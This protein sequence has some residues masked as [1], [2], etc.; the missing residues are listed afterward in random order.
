MIYAIF[1]KDD[2]GP[3]TVD[4]AHLY[5][6]TESEY[7]ADQYARI[8]LREELKKEEKGKRF[9][10]LDV[11]RLASKE[12]LTDIMGLFN[13][14]ITQMIGAFS[15][16]DDYEIITVSSA[17]KTMSGVCR[18]S[19]KARLVGDVIYMIRPTDNSIYLY[20]LGSL[21]LELLKRMALMWKIIYNYVKL[22]VDIPDIRDIDIVNMKIDGIKI[23]LTNSKLSD[24]IEVFPL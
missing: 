19:S 14:L 24:Y 3:T 10:S 9:Q 5:G 16:L 8:L 22:P 23:I 7:I 20:N 13:P 2:S 21:Y 18:K 11:Q 6:W 15:F 17:D 12:M 1:M 4:M